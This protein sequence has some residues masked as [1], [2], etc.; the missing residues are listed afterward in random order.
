MCNIQALGS[1]KNNNK[2]I[3]F[4]RAEA[5]QGHKLIDFVRAEGEAEQ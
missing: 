2:L 3:D 5:G 4:V 1:Y